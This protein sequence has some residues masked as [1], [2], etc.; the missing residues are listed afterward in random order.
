[1]K[2]ILLFLLSLSAWATPY[3]Y[4]DLLR[5]IKIHTVLKS[6]GMTQE[7]SPAV[8]MLRIQIDW[9]E[10]GET[11][12]LSKVIREN[13]GTVARLKSASKK[14]TLGSYQAELTVGSKHYYDALGTGKEYRKLV[15]ALTFRFPMPT[16]IA[17]LKVWAENPLTG[18]QELV[19]TEKIE[20]AK[21]IVMPAIAVEKRL[22]KA[23]TAENPLVLTIYAEGYQVGN[24]ERFFADAQRVVDDIEQVR[25]PGR[26]RFHYLAVF[27]PSK[28]KLGEAEDRG[29]KPVRQDS[30]LGLYFPHW[31]PF[32]RWYNVV[33]PTNEHQFRTALATVSY[34]YPLALVDDSAYWGVGNYKSYTA[35]PAGEGAFSYLLFHEFGHFLGLNEEYE[36]DGRTEL[37]HAPQIDEPWS[38]NITF[39][40]NRHELKWIKW[41]KTET[42][43]PT[44]NNVDNWQL[45]VIGA[46]VGGYAGSAPIGKSHKP[47]NHCIM[48]SGGEFCQ[49]CAE[50]IELQLRKD[51]EK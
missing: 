43:I 2:S 42:P 26:E 5:P 36:E 38:P 23:A 49:V 1:M 39:H 40:A 33:Y 22:L 41:V 4:E 8:E 18:V 47:A 11:Y 37:E 9:R 24:Q 50:A 30:F 21:A 19:L 16:G 10:A 20:P 51:A 12:T 32:G 44:P 3:P 27:A 48:E 31:D 6:A 15:S 29:P 25:L 7:F 28:L 35:I 46:Y 13:S 45:K 17:L 34:D 14:D